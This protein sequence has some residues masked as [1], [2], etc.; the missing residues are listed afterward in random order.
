MNETNQPK[1]DSNIQDTGHGINIE[2]CEIESGA[3][4]PRVHKT[5]KKKCSC[6]F[7]RKH[8]KIV[9]NIAYNFAIVCNMILM[10][11]LYYDIPYKT[12]F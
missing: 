10:C 5:N 7:K 6:F 9:S 3:N 1:N 8:C 11:N 12:N 4:S 2:I